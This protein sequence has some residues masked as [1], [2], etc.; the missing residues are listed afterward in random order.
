MEN[1]KAN[2]LIP[3]AQ[4][5]MIY[6]M[7]LNYRLKGEKTIHSL[8]FENQTIPNFISYMIRAKMF[9][10]HEWKATK[11]LIP[12]SHK[13]QAQPE[14]PI[15]AIDSS[16]V[17][18]SKPK[19][20]TRSNSISCYR[21][22]WIF[23]NESELYSQVRDSIPHILRNI[24]KPQCSYFK[25]TEEL[26]LAPKIV[27]TSIELTS[28]A[29]C[30][31][32]ETGIKFAIALDVPVK[33]HFEMMHPL[34]MHTNV[35]ALIKRYNDVGLKLE[36]LEPQILAGM[37]ITLLK[38]HRLYDSNKIEVRTVN[39]KLVQE[40]ETTLL[41][42]LVAEFYKLKSSVTLPKFDLSTS[43]YFDKQLI[44]YLN[45]LHGED[46]TVGTGTSLSAPKA[47]VEKL[48]KGTA[49]TQ[50]QRVIKDLKLT[51][52]GEERL[53]LSKLDSYAK[54]WIGIS[55]EKQA[56]L[57]T[58]CEEK[59]DLSVKSELLVKA[60]KLLP[61]MGFDEKETDEAADPLA[62]MKNFRRGA[63]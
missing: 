52:N 15:V 63:K 51:A 37:L 23:K 56:Q 32:H 8:W 12:S 5:P 36:S 6:G 60:L 59:L 24:L 44:S 28:A 43:W 38:H 62:F 18:I 14:I 20:T 49:L 21:V 17:T 42:R 50:V 33:F 34:A 55:S 10:W 58:Q 54:V 47:K 9:D 2:A 29:L 26:K 30:V 45:I 11:P 57:I 27:K 35:V 22:E 16:K 7:K 46:H 48:E 31:C 41:A 40:C 39:E 19:D 53:F 4:N 25:I 13:P 1:V 3:F 61:T